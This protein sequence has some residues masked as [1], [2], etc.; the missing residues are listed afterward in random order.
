M[1]RMAIGRGGEHGRHGHSPLFPII[2]KFGTSLNV[3]SKTR[4]GQK[5]DESMV[6]LLGE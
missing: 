2:W 5:C 1:R 3:G 6:Y 4:L